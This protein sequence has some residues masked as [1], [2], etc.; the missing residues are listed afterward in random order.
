M[1]ETILKLQCLKWQL[2]SRKFVI[3]FDSGCSKV[4]LLGEVLSRGILRLTKSVDRRRSIDDDRTLKKRCSFTPKGSLKQKV[5]KSNQ[6]RTFPLSDCAPSKA[7]L[8]KCEVSLQN[9]LRAAPNYPSP[10]CWWYGYVWRG[11][12]SRAYRCL[13][14]HNLL[15][16][17]QRARRP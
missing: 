13:S 15:L 5:R 6:M 7:S 1:R 16:V 4:R 10:K 11:L 9:A 14:F 2:S 17:K 3:L 12:V 8:L